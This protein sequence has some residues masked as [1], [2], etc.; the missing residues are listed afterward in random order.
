M[1]QLET[2]S[3]VVD[4]NVPHDDLIYFL[5]PSTLTRNFTQHQ[6]LKRLNVKYSVERYIFTHVS[7]EALPKLD[8]QSVLNLKPL[9]E[10]GL[11]V[12]A[13]KSVKYPKLVDTMDGYFSSDDDP[14][15]EQLYAK[16]RYSIF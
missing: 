6:I 14:T 7:T 9:S 13:V 2:V 15:I 8:W 12:V 4:R 1:Q 5:F 11:N 16:S 3:N 10:I